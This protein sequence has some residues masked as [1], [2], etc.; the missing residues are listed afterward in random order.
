MKTLNPEQLQATEHVEGPMLVLAGAGSGKT[1]VVTCRVAHLLK[2]GVPSS[3]ILALTFTNKAAE[4]MRERIQTLSKQFVLTCT[5]HSLGARILRESIH[6]LGYFSDFTIYDEKDSLELLKNCLTSLG[7]KSEK[8]LLKSLKIGISH[9]KN[10]V[11]SKEDLKSDFQSR[12]EKLLSESFVLYQG[13]LKEYNALDFDDLLYL[14]VK[15]FKT[16][17]DILLNY[18]KRWNFILIDEY[19]DTNAA[20]YFMTKLLSA[21]HRNLFAVGD[22]D[23]SIY[24]WR[25]ANISNILDFE[26]DYEGAQTISLEQ[27]YRST[28]MILEGANSLIACNESRYEKNLW[29]SLGPGEKIKIFLSSN[30]REEA[31]FVA[32]EILKLKRAHELPLKECVVFYRTN[33]QSR[34]FEDAFLKQN[35]PYM[36]IGGISFYQRREIKDILALLRMTVS[37]ADFLSF[38]RTINLPKRGIGPTTLKKLQSLAEELE[39]PI[40]PLCRNILKK[41]VSSLKLSAKQEKGLTSY[42][43]VIDSLKALVK[44]NTSL[45]EIVYEAI[46]QTGYLN[47]LK[48]DPQTYEERK[49]NLDALINKAAESGEEK[50]TQ[51]LINFLEELSLKSSLDDTVS[52]DAVRLMTI[53]NGK[54]LEFEAAFV[55]GLE[56]DLFPHINSKD[57]PDALE[58]ERRL[59]YVGMTRAKRHLYLTAATYRFIW[60]IPKVMRVSRFI[61]EVPAEYTTTLSQEEEVLNQGWEEEEGFEAGT[62]L[63]HKDFG[64][65]VVKKSYQTS[66][67]LTYDVYFFESNSTRSLVA[68]YAKF[69]SYS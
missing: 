54:G 1:R 8:G 36:I 16:H 63:F 48:A 31:T 57:S 53:H 23:Q 68:K 65:G 4:E 10:A 17:P 49:E 21:K 44:T 26:K 9:A 56:E 15:L 69:T 67:G 46:D 43:N 24:S 34:N 33:A 12:E 22:P 13:K 39:L 64:K 7:I 32:E 52:E 2:L 18:Q 3:E 29:S 50:E 30:E 25:G 6:A 61:K 55:V 40:L 47:L 58:E 35:I 38:T 27:N 20:Q 66:L 41:E 37:E 45:E 14:P 59:C 11:M 42:L 51:S 5:F 62:T 19:Q 28:S 60:G